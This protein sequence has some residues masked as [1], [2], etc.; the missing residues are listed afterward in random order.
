[1]QIVHSVHIYYGIYWL[2]KIT[3]RLKKKYLLDYIHPYKANLDILLILILLSKTVYRTTN[4][5]LK[6]MNLLMKNAFNY[7]IQMIVYVPKLLKN[8]A[9]STINLMI[10]V[11]NPSN[12]WMD[13]YVFRLVHMQRNGLLKIPKLSCG[14]LV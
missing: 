4:L 2:M 1:M 14:N 6:P 13:Y 5:L 7:L 12:F 11:A 3:G 8:Y 9:K 10:I